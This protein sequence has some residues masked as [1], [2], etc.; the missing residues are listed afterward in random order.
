MQLDAVKESF[1]RLVRALTS[2]YDY[3]ALR[4][5]KVVVQNDDTTLEL[6]PED[7]AWPGMSKVPIRHGIPG[8]TVKVK[9]GARVLFGFEGGDST[10]PVATL[11]DTAAVEKLEL[12]AGTIDMRPGA[13]RAIAC[14]G[15][16]V[17]IPSAKP[18]PVQ[19]FLDAAGTV[20][21]TVPAMSGPT[22]VGTVTFPPMFLRFIGPGFMA[23]G[24]VV[25][26]SPNRS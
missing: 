18:I 6:Q 16:M 22:V 25:A 2:K 8:V 21:A 23:V 1:A 11:W 26:V 13:S 20:P 17:T 4:P 15:D 19:L 7:E 10:R 5:A 14:N 9:A 12:R 24:Q 3:H